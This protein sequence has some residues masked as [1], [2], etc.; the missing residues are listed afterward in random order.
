MMDDTFMAV[1]T[2]NIQ[3]AERRSDLSASARLKQLYERIVARLRENM[4]PELRFINDLLSTKTD[5]EASALLAQEGNGYGLSLLDM[6]DAVEEV[7]AAR[8]ESAALQKLVFLREQAQ[9]ALG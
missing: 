6:M 2:A 8:G 3:E 7:L 9:R 5:E 1:L 4:Q